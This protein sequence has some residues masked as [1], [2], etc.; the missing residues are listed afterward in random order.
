MTRLAGVRICPLVIPLMLL[1]T[2]CVSNIPK[3]SS[4]GDSQLSNA[5][6]KV[7]AVQ[8]YTGATYTIIYGEPGCGLMVD[9]SPTNPPGHLLQQRS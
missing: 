9:G 8:S 6:Q 1:L 2:G 4:Y 7:L 5:A 3:V